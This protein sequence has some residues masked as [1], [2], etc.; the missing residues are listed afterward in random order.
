MKTPCPICG[1]SGWEIVER[2]GLSGAEP[3][4]CTRVTEAET[5]RPTLEQITA[6][7]L[8]MAEMIPFFPTSKAGQ[9]IVIRALESF[10][11]T[12]QQLAW[13]TDRAVNHMRKFNLPEL[14][15]LFCTR[16]KPADGVQE[17]STLPGFTTADLEAQAF[18]QQAQQTAELIEKWK[19]QKL[20]AAPGSVEP[21]ELPPG[22]KL[23][24]LPP[25]PKTRPQS[26]PS[27]PRPLSVIEAEALR[28]IGPPRSPEEIE[29]LS[30]ELAAA[31]EQRKKQG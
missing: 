4:R 9:M 27:D 22:A 18:D 3:C 7:V 14:R 13:L 19:N 8:V 10:V 23:R 16:W 17:F 11:S 26:P 28:N 29:R 25:A 5:V 31:V 2:A 6:A 24:L 1:D 30:R 15:G 20:L 21:F 12:D